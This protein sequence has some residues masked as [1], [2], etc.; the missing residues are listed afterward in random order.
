MQLFILGLVIAMYLIDLV[1]T[2]VNDRASRQPLPEQA[3]GIYDDEKFEKGLPLPPT[4]GR[5]NPP[6]AMPPGPA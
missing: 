6:A 1:V 3:H 2:L 5:G 4:P